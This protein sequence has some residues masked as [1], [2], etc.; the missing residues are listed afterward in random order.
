MLNGILS[1]FADELVDPSETVFSIFPTQPD[2]NYIHIIVKVPRTSEKEW[3][4]Q[5]SVAD[6]RLDSAPKTF[7]PFINS[8]IRHA[9]SCFSSHNQSMYV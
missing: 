3:L 8:T 4:L 1:K 6:K 5:L 2:K 7:H 9:D